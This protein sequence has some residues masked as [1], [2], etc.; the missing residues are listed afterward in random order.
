MLM[1]RGTLYGQT[2]MLASSRR[3][4][5]ARSFD[6]GQRSSAQEPA[7][8][9]DPSHG[10]D[11]G[12]VSQTGDGDS[13]QSPQT[14]RPPVSYNPT[15]RRNGTRQN[16]NGYDGPFD[17]AHRNIDGQVGD[18]IFR[19]TRR[20]GCYQGAAEQVDQNAEEKSEGKPNRA[21][22]DRAAQRESTLR[23]ES[24]QAEIAPDGISEK[25]AAKIQ[26]S[27]CHLRPP[28]KGN[29]L[30]PAAIRPIVLN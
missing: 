2:A 13:A 26:K 9:N 12:N 21:I 20:E 5:R 3:I 17:P 11:E 8:R 15:R 10:N 14:I 30:F 18:E 24:A 6:P 22:D 25:L 16:Q 28:V 1:V 27:S 19:K 29:C 7:D 23:P 4:G